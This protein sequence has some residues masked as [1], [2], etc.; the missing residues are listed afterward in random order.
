MQ[1]RLADAKKPLRGVRAIVAKGGGDDAHAAQQGGN[2][3]LFGGG[4]GGNSHLFGG[5][6]GVPNRWDAAAQGTVAGGVHGSL[7]GGVIPGGVHGSL[8]GGPSFQTST[9]IVFSTHQIILPDHQTT[10]SLFQISSSP[11]AR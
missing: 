2:S 10:T 9:M 8:G 1:P 3:H 7:G 11:T 5:G 4:S 6:S